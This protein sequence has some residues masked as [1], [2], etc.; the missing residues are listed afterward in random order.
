M[1]IGDNACFCSGVGINWLEPT[2]RMLHV[3][4]MAKIFDL[5]LF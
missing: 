4:C 1:C 3:Q 2:I 5:R